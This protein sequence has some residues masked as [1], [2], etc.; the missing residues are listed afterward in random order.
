MPPHVGMICGPITTG[1]LGS[2]KANLQIFN[3]TIDDLVSR[4]V[5]LFDQIPFE[6]HFA[7][8]KAQGNGYDTR[9]LNEFYLTL[10]ESGQ[11]TR[12]HMIPGWQSSGGA[13]WEHAQAQR[14]K[15]EIVYL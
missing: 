12:L 13:T 1:G 10:F 8:I 4:G 3:E 11:I 7:R 9:L 14:L 5:N 15:I 6:E 2:I